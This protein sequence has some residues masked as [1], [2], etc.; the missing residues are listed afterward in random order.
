[1]ELLQEKLSSRTS[2]QREDP[3]PT[4]ELEASG[5]PGSASGFAGL[6]RDDNR[7]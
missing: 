6:V 3:G 2:A 4:R 7:F 1:M 5:G